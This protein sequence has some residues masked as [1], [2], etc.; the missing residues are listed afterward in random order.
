MPSRSVGVFPGE[1]ER[2]IFT[3]GGR[4]TRPRPSEAF[5][6][7]AVHGQILWG[8]A[9]SKVQRACGSN[10]QGCRVELSRPGKRHGAGGGRDRRGRDVS[11]RGGFRRNNLH[12]ANRFTRGRLQRKPRL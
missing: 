10:R 12:L 8:F 9:F 5:D 6:W 11:T 3:V 7:H 2:S 1:F 4:R